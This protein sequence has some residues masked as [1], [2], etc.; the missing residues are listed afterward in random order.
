MMASEAADRHLEH[1]FGA[2]SASEVGAAYDEWA[3]TYDQDMLSVG[4]VHPAVAA[5]MVARYVGDRDRPILDA[6]CGT[7]INGQILSTVGYSSAHGLDLSPG[8]LARAR[9][10]SVYRELHEGVLGD[11][12]PF[13]D[14]AFG[15]VVATGVFT[16]GHAPPDAFDELLRVTRTGGTFIFSIARNIWNEGGF[17]EKLNDLEAGRQ[18]ELVEET[19][20]YH[21]MPFSEAEK[22]TAARMFVYRVLKSLF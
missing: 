6:G 14:D 10:R 15:A 5:A 17:R 1:V 2:K 11:R 3:P 18:C 9:E 20:W 4:Y 8:M 12:L 13:P 19:P 7:G 21:S 16:R 22:A